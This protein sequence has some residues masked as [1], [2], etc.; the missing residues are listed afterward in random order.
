[1]ISNGQVVASFV[2]ANA[3]FVGNLSASKSR[4]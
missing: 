4:E 3:C 2:S 1:M